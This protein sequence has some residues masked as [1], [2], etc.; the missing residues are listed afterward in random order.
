MCLSFSVIEKEPGSASFPS[1]DRYRSPRSSD[2]AEVQVRIDGTLC[3]ATVLGRNG[4]RVQLR[5]ALDGASYVRWF[6]RADVLDGEP[7]PD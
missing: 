4:P 1:T 3:A 7:A 2:D 5:F 6:D